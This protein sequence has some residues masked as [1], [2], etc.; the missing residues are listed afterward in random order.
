MI[1]FSTYEENFPNSFGFGMG[2]EFRERMLMI[3]PK[4]VNYNVKEGNVYCVITCL[5]NLKNS[6]GFEYS[7]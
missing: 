2:Y 6:K 3:S 7:M 1:K 5:K 4:N